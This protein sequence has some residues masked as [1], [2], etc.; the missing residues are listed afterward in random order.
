MRFSS[1][2]K[3]AQACVKESFFPPLESLN[4]KCSMPNGMHKNSTSYLLTSFFVQ[5]FCMT[6]TDVFKANISNLFCAASVTV[7]LPTPWVKASREGGVDF[8]EGGLPWGIFC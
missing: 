1:A 5:F 7:R 3:L 6:G 4:W 2:K 8:L